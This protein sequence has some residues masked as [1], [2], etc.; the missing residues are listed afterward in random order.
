MGLAALDNAITGLRVSQQQ[1]GAVSGNIA[2]ATTPG[3]TRKSLPVQ[4]QVLSGQGGG[5]VSGQLIRDIDLNLQ[6]NVWTQI[7]AVNSLG[8]QQ[9][10]L[11]SV[12]EF[13]GPPDSEISIAAEVNRLHDS[14]AALSDNPSNA[15]L[16][17]NTVNQ[18]VDTAQ[19]INDFSR[20]LNTLRSDVQNELLDTVARI[21]ELVDQIANINRN[22][23]NFS[24]VNTSAV[25][26]EDQRDQSIKELSE[27]ISVNH[28]IRGDG[29][30]VV[31]AVNGVELA[32]TTANQI[33]YTTGV[34]SQQFTY[35]DDIAGILVTDPRLNNDQGIDIT[36][37]DVGGKLGGLITLRDTTFPK[38]MAQ[39]DELAH[40]MALR[41]DAQ[42]LKLFTDKTGVIPA[43]TAPN[44]TTDT[45]VE[46]VGFASEIRVNPAVIAD[47]TLVRSG[48]YGASIPPS[49]NEVINRIIEFT[50]GSVDFEQALNSSTSTSVDLLNR[51]GDDLQTW[52]GLTSS[53]TITG[54]R[55]LSSFS[56]AAALIA[57]AGSDLGT[58]SNT[59]RL[60]F[61]ESRT[62]T[63]P[64]NI[65]IDLSAVTDG[66]GNLVSDLNTYITGT[67]IPALSA[68]NQT[69][70]ATMGVTFS[71]GTNGEWVINSQGS[72]VIDGQNPTNPMG[73]T[74]LDY[75]GLIDNVGDA[76]APTD[77]YFDIAVGENQLTRITIEP[78]DTHTDL[79][80]KLDA[81]PGLAIDT[82]NFALDGFLRLRPGNDYDD[83]D[84]GGSLRIIGG[85]FVTDSASLGSPPAAAGRTA[86]DDGVNIVSALFGTYTA[87]TPVQNN[88]AISQVLYGSPTDASLGTPP[89]V[90]F[91]ISYLGADTAASTNV[92]GAS[93]LISYAQQMVYEHTGELN[94][95]EARAKDEDTLREVLETRFLDE[96]GVNI[97][98]ELSNLIVFQTQYNAAARMVAA[99]NE[100]F[101]QLLQVV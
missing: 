73:Q 26:L 100:L 85:P 92:S 83:P 21:N 84:F 16:L 53:N 82:V 18:A 63:G 67:L 35:P 8:V 15:F 39:L 17:N 40:K 90:P 72:I 11:N 12:M 42:G 99:I 43:D 6:S 47:N 97:D 76:Q 28:Y 34:I 20:L 80:N 98:T 55:S 7:S 23:F 66:A 51:G 71:Q 81:V 13:H 65:D 52:L 44:S 31:Q 87:G 5:A 2:N 46:Y 59:L 3:Y 10:Y 79:L 89:N 54:G 1:L 93:T 29:V 94:R 48:T 19:K 38:Q 62:S 78:G 77:P 75:L 30:M 61:E 4:T 64:V 37:L 91:R 56:S 96:A 86:I 60:T 45:P 36:Q 25:A 74:G 101:D 69:A 50:F 27:L 22:I 33:S 49:S 24:N 70:L 57:S 95:L 41:F 9:R 68:G 58:S 32:S 88:T 14:F